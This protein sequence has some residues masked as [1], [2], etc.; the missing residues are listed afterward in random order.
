MPLKHNLLN[1]IDKLTNDCRINVHRKGPSSFYNFLAKSLQKIK[2]SSYALSLSSTQ[3]AFLGIL[4]VSGIVTTVGQSFKAYDMIGYDTMIWYDM[5][6]DMIYL[7]TAIGLTPGDSSTAYIYTQTIKWTTQ[8]TT[9]V[10]RLSEIRTQ[11]GQNE[12]NDELTA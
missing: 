1:K 11:S 3:R 9:L 4:N 10:G 7:L 8:L 2:L 6:H 12:I 5:I